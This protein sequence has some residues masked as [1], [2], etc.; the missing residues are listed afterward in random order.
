[1]KYFEEFYNCKN[2][3]LFSDKLRIKYFQ[4]GIE[5][6]DIVWY[7]I[8]GSM[9]NG[10]REKWIKL[11][12]V[13]ILDNKIIVVTGA[14]QGIGKAISERFLAEGAIVYGVDL[15]EG[16]MAELSIDSHFHPFYFDITDQSSIRDLFVT[17][18]KTS[19]FVDGF[20]WHAERDSNPRPSA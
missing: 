8:I 13:K 1:M 6:C 11:N 7:N 3:P 18:Q 14:G 2:L 5:K 12:K 16:S 10:E 20:F 9:M 4:K 17:I 15:Q 19:T